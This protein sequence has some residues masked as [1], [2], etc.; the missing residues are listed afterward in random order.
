MFD[1]ART[2]TS[3]IPYCDIVVTDKAMASHIRRRGLG[4]RL[5][6]VVLPPRRPLPASDHPLRAD[7]SSRL[8]DPVA[9]AV[10]PLL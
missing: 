9:R 2:N 1:R 6:T 10:M 7:R 8:D 5:G 4:E 3:S